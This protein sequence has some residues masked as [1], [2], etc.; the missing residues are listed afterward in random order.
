MATPGIK[1]LITLSAAIACGFLLVI[2]SCAL[3]ANWMPLLVATSFIL[4]PLPNAICGRYSNGEDFMTGDSGSGVA[5]L[6][7]FLTGALVATGVCMLFYSPLNDRNNIALPILLA[8]SG[9]ILPIVC[10]MSL[11]GGLT[12]Y[13]T[14][15]TFT[16]FFTEREDY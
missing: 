7:Q 13:V 3:F 15:I 16:Y 6:G 10:I 12:I 2:L 8:H 11:V 9:I 14:I 4:A 5:D 1:T